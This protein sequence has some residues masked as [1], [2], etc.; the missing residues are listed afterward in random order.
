MTHTFPYLVTK[1]DTEPFTVSEMREWLRK[2]IPGFTAED[3]VIEQ[4]IKSA[5]KHVE[6]MCEVQFGVSSFEWICFGI[7]PKVKR[8]FVI[9]ITRISGYDGTGYT[10]IPASDYRFI[11]AGEFTNRIIWVKF[12]MAY[13]E[14]KVEFTAGF[15]TVPDDLRQGCRALI[16]E[17]DEGRV[18][19]VKE[20]ITMSDR[21]IAPYKLTYAG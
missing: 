15:E 3:G 11:K 18:D 10:E 20:K 4:L 12:P 6:E 17:W 19:G 8:Y 14:F 7:P 21:L 16:G 5:V 2:D 9:G 1:Y 13:T